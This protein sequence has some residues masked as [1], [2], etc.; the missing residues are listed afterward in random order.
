[1]SETH[2]INA[3]RNFEVKVAPCLITKQFDRCI[4][5]KLGTVVLPADE[6]NEERVVEVMGS[7]SREGL[8]TL[9]RDLESVPDPIGL[10]TQE[11]VNRDTPYQW[12][13]VM[14]DGEHY[15]QYPVEGGETPFSSIHLPDVDQFW[16]MPRENP[17]ALPWYGLMRGKGWFER[18]TDGVTR[19]MNL[20]HPGDE[21]F[22]WHY[23]RHNVITFAMGG[24]ECET[25]PPHVVQCLGWRLPRTN[26]VDVVFEIGVEFEGS[27]QV[28]KREPLDDPR[29]E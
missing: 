21:P 27:W 15:Q 7:F 6:L 13:V 25:L 4:V 9:R 14:E 12:A 23:Y 20:P 16:I 8:D 17:N 10:P 24:G 26:Q 19:P 11:A 28:W 1:M 2:T 22:E 29:W 18:G 3:D 5:V